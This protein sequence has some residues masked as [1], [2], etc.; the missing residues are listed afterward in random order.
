MR[1]LAVKTMMA[2]QTDFTTLPLE[3]ATGISTM[4]GREGSTIRG[5]TRLPGI[6]KAM[7]IP[8]GIVMRPVVSV[9]ASP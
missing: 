9:A 4:Y 3:R 2:M 7:R 1:S 8:N 5:M 6:R